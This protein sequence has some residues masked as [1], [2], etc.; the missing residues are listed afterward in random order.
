M[1][2]GGMG[3]GRQGRRKDTFGICY[4]WQCAQA[5]KRLQRVWI[6]VVT[7]ST[8]KEGPG[9]LRALAGALAWIAGMMVWNGR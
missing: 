4:A 9:L 3:R 1:G 6:P 8:S 7:T 2:R 5:Y